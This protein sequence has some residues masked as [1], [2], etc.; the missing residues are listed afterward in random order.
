[1]LKKIAETALTGKNS[2]IS[3]DHLT[4]IVVKAVISIVDPDGTAD[5]SH[6][7]VEKKVGGSVDD[8][9]LVQGMVIN[10]ERGNP[11][12]PKSVENAKILVLN[13]ALEYKKTDVN[14]KINISS[15]GQAQAFLDEEEHMVHIM[16]DKVL[17]VKANVVFCQKGIDD[18]A[19]ALPDKSR[20]PCRPQ[21]K[22]ERRREPCPGN[23]SKHRQQR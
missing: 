9:E 11:N 22:E 7:N 15:P 13:T 17:R 6:I 12:M 10:K 23:R 19:L 14:A 18:V 4:D 20:Y 1:M 2:D 3:K 5:I 21:D 8:S 16:V